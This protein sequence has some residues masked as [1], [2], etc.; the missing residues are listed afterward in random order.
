MAQWANLGNMGVGAQ[1]PT[2]MHPSGMSMYQTVGTAGGIS[3][4]NI[5]Q[6]VNLQGGSKGNRIQSAINTANT[7][8]I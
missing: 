7:S 6:A 2:M 3:V 5:R 4:P 8:G 1:F